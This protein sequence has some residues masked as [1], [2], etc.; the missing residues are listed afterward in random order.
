MTGV[1]VILAFM[2]CSG[3]DEFQGLDQCADGTVVARTCDQAEAHVRMGL[4]PGQE[5]LITR[6]CRPYSP[7]QPRD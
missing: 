4:R 7:G 6:P 3:G 5:L 1:W 2:V